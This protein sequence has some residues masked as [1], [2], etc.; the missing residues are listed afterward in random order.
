MR[1]EYIYDFSK[2]KSIFEKIYLPIVEWI[3]RC[4]AKKAETDQIAENMSTSKIHLCCSSVKK[5]SI[6]NKSG[7]DIKSIARRLWSHQRAPSESNEA[8]PA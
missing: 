5:L 7:P 8:I 1:A 6:I 2:C 4:E 3:Y